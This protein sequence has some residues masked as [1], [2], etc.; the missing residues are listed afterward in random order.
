[1]TGL[2]QEL[3]TERLVAIIRNIPSALLP[4]TCEALLSGGI[5]FVEVTLHPGDPAATHDALH[6]IEELRRRFDMQLHIG[7]GTVLTPEAVDAAAGAGAEFILA[8][9]TTPAVIRRAKECGLLT[10]PGAFTPTEIEHAWTAGADIV[11]VFPA[12]LL[13]APY[14][15]A[16]QGP[17]PHIPLSAVGGTSTDNIAAFL[18]GGAVVCG[19]GGNLVNASRAIHGAWDEIRE[20]A[21]AYCRIVSPWRITDTM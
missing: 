20:T 17:L 1:M 21:A 19:I 8:P 11:K 15:K 14:F 5:R 16:L 7:A 18:D 9:N 6:G 3:L 10:M 2:H 4:P 13:G 12:D